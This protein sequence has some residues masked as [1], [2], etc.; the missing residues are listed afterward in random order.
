[1]HSDHDTDSLREEMETLRSIVLTT[2]ML[3][4]SENSGAE[5]KG[6][7]RIFIESTG[8]AAL[9]TVLLG[10]IVAGLITNEY[11]RHMKAREQQ[12]AENKAISEQ[13]ALTYKEYLEQGKETVTKTYDLVGKCISESD[14]LIALAKTDFFTGAFNR[15]PKI[16]NEML[17]RRNAVIAEFN[18]TDSRW[19]KERDTVGLLMSHHHN[20]DAEVVKA[21]RTVQNSVTEY[22]TCAQRYHFIKNLAYDYVERFDD[23]ECEDHKSALQESLDSFIRVRL[24]AAKIQAK[25]TWNRDSKQ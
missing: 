12:Q 19:R 22:L 20:G 8:G 15:D 10:G 24:E 4:R 13:A 9:I 25:A 7:W 1:M 18:D 16:K 5:K 2:E 21:W 14:E 3:K 17:R 11:Q 23:P 6:N